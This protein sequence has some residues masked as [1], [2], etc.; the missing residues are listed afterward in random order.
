MEVEGVWNL[1]GM[2]I[3][4]FIRAGIRTLLCVLVLVVEAVVVL[5][6]VCVWMVPTLWVVVGVLAVVTMMV[7]KFGRS[8][9]WVE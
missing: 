3:L 2:G 5:P 1:G 8:C 9:F 4:S 7:Q 6:R